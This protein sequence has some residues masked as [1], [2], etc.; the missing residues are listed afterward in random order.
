MNQAA[1]ELAGEA[2]NRAKGRK[3]SDGTEDVIK[4][5]PLKEAIAELETLKTKADAAKDRLNDA[6][7]AVAERSGLLSKVVRKLVNARHGEGFE[8]AKRE[9]DQLAIVFDEVGNK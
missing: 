6:I 2:I 5:K 7:K 1:T 9:V 4:V 8:D 3:S